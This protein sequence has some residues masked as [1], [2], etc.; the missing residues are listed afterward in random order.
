MSSDSDVEV[1]EEVRRLHSTSYPCHQCRMA[2]SDHG[3][4][5]VQYSEEQEDQQQQGEAGPN[6]P[7]RYD[8]EGMH[9]KLEDIG[10]TQDVDWQ[11]TLII[12]GSNPTEVSNI[13]DDL[14]RELAFYNQVHSTLAA[15]GMLPVTSAAAAACRSQHCQRLLHHALRH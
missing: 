5:C 8:V 12:D 1:S 13:D 14:E 7:A 11:E 10:W 15:P 9:E 4:A 6:K 3:F 2:T